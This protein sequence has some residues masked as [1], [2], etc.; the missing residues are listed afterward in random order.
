MS[1]AILDV[2]DFN[3]RCLNVE[4][5]AVPQ[6]ER[7]HADF[8]VKAF[9]EEAQELADQHWQTP[10]PVAIHWEDAQSE[11]ARVQTVKS[12]DAC[13]DTAYFAIG[14]MARA[15]LTEAQAI[16][17]FRAV[18]EANMTKKL[19]VVASRGDMGVPDATKPADFVPP[20][21]MIYEILFGQPPSEHGVALLN[22]KV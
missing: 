6:M 9:R 12:V 10:H 20:D 19:G 1:D 22:A 18:H 14:G 17:C 2:F 15:G 13:I 16:M 21:Q 8:C 7:K 5:K 3:R 4:T 11:E